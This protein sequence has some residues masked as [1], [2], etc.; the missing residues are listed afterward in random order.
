MRDK[1]LKCNAK[2]AFFTGIKASFTALA[3]ISWERMNPAEVSSNGH[4]IFSQSRTMSLR[5]ADLMAIVM[6]KLK[7]KE[8][9]LLP[10]IWERN[11]SREVLKG[12]TIASWKIP[13]FVSL[14]SK[15]I[16]LK[17]S[18]SRWTRTRR[19][20]SPIECR[21]T[22]TFDT[23]RIDG[24]LSISLEKPDRW[25]IVLTSTKRWLNCTVFTKSLEKNNSHRFLTGNTSNG[26]HHLLHPAHLG[27]RGTIPGWAHD[28]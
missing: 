19:N 6:G 27:G 15:L 8:N 10:I 16:E 14:N 2:N 24:S 17:K 3:G 28:K 9:I 13:N 4:W 11:A 25:E 22:S 5:K 7:N 20:I 23:K 1:F 12:F 26:T 21:P 18:A